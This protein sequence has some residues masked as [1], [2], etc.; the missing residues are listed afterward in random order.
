VGQV[1]PT[2]LPRR[3]TVGEKPAC[4]S[5]TTSSGHKQ[6]STSHQPGQQVIFLFFYSKIEYVKY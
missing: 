4:H 3:A 2:S 6:Q 5:G 1:P